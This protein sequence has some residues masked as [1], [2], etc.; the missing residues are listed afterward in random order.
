MLPVYA[1]IWDE[2]LREFQSQKIFT[3]EFSGI[4]W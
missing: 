4:C 3:V 2:I 1:L